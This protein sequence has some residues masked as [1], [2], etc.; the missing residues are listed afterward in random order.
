MDKTE[1]ASG[2]KPQPAKKPYDKP[3]LS[4]LGTLRDLTMTKNVFA[5]SKDGKFLRFTGRGGHRVS[6]D[7]RS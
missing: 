3:V 5:G 1:E 7:H 4:N 2:A 6:V